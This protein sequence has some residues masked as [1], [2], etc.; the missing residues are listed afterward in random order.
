MTIQDI[1]REAGVSTATVS[2][3]L[4]NKTVRADS[5]TR[6][7]TAIKKLHY[8]PDAIARSLMGKRSKAI[9]VLI[10]S[11]TNSYYMEITEVI[12]KRFR[13]QGSRLFICSTDGNSRAEDEYLQDLVSRRV[14]GIIVIDPSMENYENRVF[15][16]IAARLPLVLLHSWTE[17][18]GINS[19]FIDQTHGMMQVMQYLWESGHRRIAFVRGSSA[20][21]SYDIKENCWKDFLSARD[22]KIDLE[23]LVSLQEGNTEEAIPFAREACLGLLDYDPELRPTAIFA[24]N[25]LMAL[26][27]F[28]A[29]HDLGIAV[30][31]NLSII[32]HDNTVLAFNSYPPMTTV[33][34]KMRS[35]G[36]AAAD[37]L[38]HAMD[39]K[40][41]EPRR[42]MIDPE[43]I[44]RNS[45]GPVRN[46]G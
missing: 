5:Q 10:T 4:N 22:V 3:V 11:M 37:L 45:T 20:S 43:L 13:E 19:V 6:V 24:C 27:V 8:V 40:D 42:V 34:L 21:H 23:W 26:G 39:P 36:N 17:F 7:D 2:R 46:G 38:L 12:E 32:G 44:V 31:E 30:P 35:L 28:A 18:S 9:G 29:A 41:P 15:Q 16:K 25:D 33:D 1:A 14:D